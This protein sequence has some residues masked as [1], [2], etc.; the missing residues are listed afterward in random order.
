MNSRN[1]IGII[2]IVF[3]LSMLLGINFGRI[4]FPLFVIGMGFF[5]L[6]GKVNL[7]NSES[8]SSEEDSI[9]EVVIFSDSNRVV[10]S[11]N[12]NGGKV[13]SVFADTDIDLTK[14]KSKEKEIKLELVSVFSD[15]NIKIPKG[16]T[17]KSNAVG[18]LGDVKD[19]GARSNKEQIRLLVD[20]VSVLGTIK[21]NN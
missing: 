12:F 8:V 16:W 20:G 14:V 18:I 7:F 13:V 5:L 1:V 10:E 3:G 21:I 19:Q 15:L 4:I 6:R 9:N 17:V 11:N 2:L